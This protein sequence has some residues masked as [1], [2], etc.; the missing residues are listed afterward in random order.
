[1]SIYI[2]IALVLALAAL[3]YVALPLVRRREVVTGDTMTVVD[4][5]LEDLL[6]SRE[7]TYEAIKDLAF[8]RDMG[9]LSEE[10]YRQLDY[11]YRARAVNILQNLERVEKST[12][13]DDLDAWIEE[14]VRAARQRQASP[15]AAKEKKSRSRRSRRSKR[16]PA[17][18]SAQCPSCDR[19]Y[20]VGD[21][22]CSGCGTALPP[23]CD[24][25]GATS[26][27]ESRFCTQCG[28]ELSA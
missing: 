1:M 24:S 27:P 5:V 4:P 26:R 28:A 14:A 25:C 23:L 13:G 22:F 9:K 6:F 20:G 8:E 19:P 7:V 21:R 12:L 16:R 17:A 10:D 18:K 3:A 15:K 11:Q 2:V